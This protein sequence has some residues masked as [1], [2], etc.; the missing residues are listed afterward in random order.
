MAPDVPLIGV[1][2][3]YAEAAWASWNRPASVVPA[4]YF[5]LVAQAGGRPLL[6]P[7]LRDERCVGASEVTKVLDGLLLIGGGDLD[8][9]S[10]GQTGHDETSGVDRSRDDWERALLDEALERDLPV[11]A[12]CRGH[13]VLNVH[14][15]GTLHQHVPDVVGHLGHQP[16][17]GEFGEIVVETVAGTRTASIFGPRARVLCSHHQGIDLVAPGLVVS[18]HAAAADDAELIEAVELPGPTFVVGLQ[19]HPE[20]Q[21]DERPFRALVRASQRVAT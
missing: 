18:A 20:E 10:Y 13:Q 6:L 5:E 17:F 14:L 11:L 7:P 15:G 4:N 16:A 19:W 1:S 8:P 3:Y 12:V 21:G 9:G 2:T